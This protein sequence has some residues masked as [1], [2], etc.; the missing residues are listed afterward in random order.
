[1]STPV[2][3]RSERRRASLDVVI[4]CRL[5]YLTAARLHAL[6][7]TEGETVA[8]VSRRLLE[9]GLARALAAER[10]EAQS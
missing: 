3:A 5:P 2:S 9:D 4:A 1:V 10:G 7:D 6:A 8:R